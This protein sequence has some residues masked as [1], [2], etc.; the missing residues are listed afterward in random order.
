MY[1]KN[2]WNNNRPC[3]KFRFSHVNVKSIRIQ[4][5]LFWKSRKFMVLFKEWNN[6]FQWITITN[7]DNFKS[8]KY[9][10]KLLGNTE[11]QPNPNQLN[12]IL[13]N[14]TIS[15]SFKHLSNF[16]LKCHWS[17][18][19]QNEN[20]NEQCIVFFLQL[21]IIVLIIIKVILFSL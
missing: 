13:K 4:F 9:K 3:W 19:K 5:K 16:H 21:V 8:F 7:I 20:V 17:I 12:R 2:S 18:A 15:V 14:T 11:A 1:H 10:A 6:F